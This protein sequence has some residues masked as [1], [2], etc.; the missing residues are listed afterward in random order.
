MRKELRLLKRKSEGQG[1]YFIGEESGIIGDMEFVEKIENLFEVKDGIYEL[2]TCNGVEA[3]ED[4]WS[5][6]YIEDYDYRLVPF[7]EMAVNKE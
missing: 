5:L 3:R 6:G 2:V 1:I 4:G 7:E